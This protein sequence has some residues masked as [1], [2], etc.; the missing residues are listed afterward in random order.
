M[1]AVRL[2]ELRDNATLALWNICADAVAA[3]INRGLDTDFDAAV[4]KFERRLERFGR[5]WARAENS[6][7]RKLK[8]EP[9]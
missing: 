5:S 6:Q 7:K 3:C 9:T 8:N 1:A 4:K 2:D